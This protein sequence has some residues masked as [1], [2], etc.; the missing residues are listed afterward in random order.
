MTAKHRIFIFL[1]TGILPD[2][3]LVSI[4]LPSAE[5]LG[6]LSSKV[7]GIWALNA[8]GR[9]GVGN[10][11]RYNNSRCFETFPFADPGPE[12]AATI[13]ELAEQLDAHRKRQQS[14]HPGLSLTGMY[15][16]LDKLRSG[17]PLGA[18]DKTIHEQGLVSVL[19]QLHDELD[20]AVLTAYGWGDL[21]PTLRIAHGLD[22]PAE[23]QSREDAK[24]AFDEAVL[25]RLVALNAERAAEEAR[26][27]IR[28]LRP[29]FQ[30]PEAQQAST[31][32][33]IDS[34]DDAEDI[35]API[36]AKAQAWPKDPLE[37]VRAVAE[38][39][40]QA[41]APLSLDAIAAQFK[42]RGPWKKR[43]PAL[44]DML[45]AVG[46]AQHQADGYAVFR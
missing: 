31:Q 36:A 4:A 45:I 18:K 2:Q 33:E 7:H 20:A 22:A 14:E 9:L 29:D 37:Q 34:G 8:G 19:R 17:E 13:R 15:N 21:I 35:I 39:L 25:E 24:Q 42:G 1:D 26:G 16:V 27:L 3:G 30:N 44:L 23:G 10:D 11:P 12:Q 46:Q 6:V 5:Y 43:L 41:P 38:L 32:T 40:R 28:Y